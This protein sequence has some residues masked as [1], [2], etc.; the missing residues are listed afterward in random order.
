M[1]CWAWEPQPCGARRPRRVSAALPLLGDI[2]T[3]PASRRLASACPALAPECQLILARTLS[4]ECL[5]H[6]PRQN[7]LETHRIKL[8]FSVHQSYAQN[9]EQLPW[10]E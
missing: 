2:T 5:R 6:T 10:A 8:L 4:G 7:S 1:G 9:G 3:S